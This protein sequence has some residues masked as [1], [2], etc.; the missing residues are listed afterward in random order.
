[1]WRLLTV[2][3]N[4]RLC[5][6]FAVC[7]AAMA[8]IFGVLILRYP[9]PSDCL[10]SQAS[11]HVMDCKYRTL[12]VYLSQSDDYHFPCTIDDVSPYLIKSTLCFEDRWF[13]W[14]F[15]INPVST[16]RALWINVR[17]GEV[18]SGGSTIT[19]QVARLMEPR[20]RTISSKIIEAFRALQLELRY[21][22]R[23]ILEAYFNL[24]TYG[25][26]IRGVVAASHI[27]FGKSPSELGPG[28][29]ALLAVLPNSPTQLRPDRHPEQATQRRNELL[30][31]MLKS[32]EIDSQIYQTALT[33]SV[34]D[35][36]QQFPLYAPHICDDLYQ[37]FGK[38]GGD[39]VTTIDLDV[40]QLV[41]GLL[42]RHLGPLREKNITNGAVVILDNASCAVRALVGSASYFN[43]DISGQVNGATSPRSP[44]SALKPFAYAIGLDEGIIS[45]MSLL[46]DVPVDYS[47]YRP[48]NY[49]ETY[50]GMV[51]VTD[52]LTRSM[53]VPA[54]NLVNTVGYGKFYSLLK[55]GGLTTLDQSCEYY[56]LT[57]VLGGAGVNLLELTNLYAMLANGGNYRPY[58]ILENEPIRSGN[59][60]LSNAA[61]YIVTD[62]LSKLKRPDFPTIWDASLHLPKIAWKTGT[63]YGHRDAWS[64]GYT[65][66]HTIGVWVG[67]FSGEGSPA[68]VGADAAVPL[69]FDIATA[70]ESDGGLWFAMPDDVSERLVCA[71]SGMVPGP[72]CHNTKKELYIRGRSPRQQ[73]TMHVSY[74][75]DDE[76]GVRLCSQCQWGH[77]YHKETFVQYPPELATW[78]AENGYP[79]DDIPKHNPEC[80]Q[81]ASGIGPVIISPAS[82][83][84]YVLRQ[85]IPLRDQQIH[86]TASVPNEVKMIYWFVDGEL[87]YHGRPGN[88]VLYSPALGRHEVVCMDDEGRK[89]ERL[90]I[91]I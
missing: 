65:P 40:Q 68:L 27:Y 85:G 86:L 41:Q 5:R 24:A 14:H 63:S 44:G 66:A 49:D 47:G 33:E 29:A 1:M 69:L 21:S 19:Q 9:L 31:R 56:G 91:I 7:V 50:R 22:K 75:I 59:S 16:L 6:I 84:Q 8:G 73:C 79:T 54:I 12:R 51:T 18:L 36:R 17:A 37:R 34:P 38:Q 78:M 4:N 10:T 25:G 70:L 15:G 30:R 3:F 62:I 82:D 46:Y 72:H 74:A 11:L 61:C 26:N 43:D 28:E 57:L 80:R 23:E 81:I 83:C 35:S 52:A 55:S 76:T 58:R 89:S 64:I 32:G 71:V 60:L 77:N 87:L 90:L 88:P 20:P 53:N 45:P 42:D 2:I 13:F 39:V 67:N 48:Q